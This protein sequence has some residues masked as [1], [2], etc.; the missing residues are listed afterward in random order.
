MFIRNG[1]TAT[2]QM[3]DPR[4]RVF[5]RGYMRETYGPNIPG[6]TRHLLIV[7]KSIPGFNV[8][9]TGDDT[10]QER[11]DVGITRKYLYKIEGVNECRDQYQ[12]V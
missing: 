9:S 7:A 2:Y 6:K 12:N 8:A 4:R 11:M 1:Q 10:I 5:T 3:R